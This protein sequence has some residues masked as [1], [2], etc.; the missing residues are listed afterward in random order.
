MERFWFLLLNLRII[1]T[2]AQTKLLT[3]EKFNLFFKKLLPS[4]HEHSQAQVIQMI[5]LTDL[6]LYFSG[7]NSPS[8]KIMKT[9][10]KKATNNFKNEIVTIFFLK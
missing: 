8:L 1:R 10:G 6:L 4:V 5:R 9:L 7:F 2:K 3:D